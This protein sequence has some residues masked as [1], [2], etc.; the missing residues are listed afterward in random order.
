MCQ[1]L[2]RFRCPLRSS[3]PRGPKSYAAPAGPIFQGAL[4]PSCLS[5]GRRIPFAGASLED[6]YASALLRSGIFPVMPEAR[7][8]SSSAG[9]QAQAGCGNVHWCCSVSGRRTTAKNHRA[10]AFEPRN[11]P[12]LP[13]RHLRGAAHRSPHP[14]HR[15][16]CFARG[17]HSSKKPACRCR[18]RRAAP[19]SQRRRPDRNLPSPSP[20]CAARWSRLMRSFQRRKTVY[21]DKGRF[22]ASPNGPRTTTRADS[23]A[24]LAEAGSDPDGDGC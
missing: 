14:P 23:P 19:H 18:R 7:H 4:Q 17:R 10:E 12:P 3:K 9:L 15:Q 16:T 6:A 21:Q 22:C 24:H 8:P 5:F 13:W 11:V 20:E 2:R 1:C